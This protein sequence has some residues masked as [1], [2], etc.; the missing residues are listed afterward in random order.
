[1]STVDPALQGLLLF[2][3]G[4]ALCE[5]SGLAACNANIAEGDRI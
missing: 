2:C 3:E 4:F 1:M 5:T